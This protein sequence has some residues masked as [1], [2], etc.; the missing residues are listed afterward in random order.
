MLTMSYLASFTCFLFSVHNLQGTV[1][2]VHTT[3][4][5]D[6]EDCPGILT[7][8]F[9]FLL[10]EP[11]EKS[12]FWDTSL[13]KNYTQPLLQKTRLVLAVSYSDSSFIPWELAEKSLST[14]HLKKFVNWATYFFPYKILLFGTLFQPEI[15]AV[16]QLF[17]ASSFVHSTITPKHT[18]AT[19]KIP[20][21]KNYSIFIIRTKCEMCAHWVH[22]QLWGQNTQCA[23]NKTWIIK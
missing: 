7:S 8:D 10:W 23:Y 18:Q 15:N 21:L 1:W 12:P 11:T 9:S 5:A 20:A 19:G 16:E 14:K 4:A 22:L 17:Q 3:L 13:K 6:D 2:W